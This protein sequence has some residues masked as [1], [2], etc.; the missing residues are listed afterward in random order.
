MEYVKKYE[1]R[2]GVDAGYHTSNIHPTNGEGCVGKNGIDKN[3]TL[4]QVMLIAYKME[5]KPN[6]I[7][8][9]GPNA[10]WYIKKFIPEL[11]D[12]E[13]ENQRK[14]RDVSRCTMHIIEWD[15]NH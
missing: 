4:E 12:N 5:Q 15:I 13:I 8:K 10:K 11:I 7:I 1:K 6:V 3:Y 2:I 9:A 14:W